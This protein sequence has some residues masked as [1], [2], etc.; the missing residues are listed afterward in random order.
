VS[1]DAA[2]EIVVWFD[3]RNGGDNDLFAL[4]LTAYGTRASG[5][6]VNGNPVCTSPGSQDTPACCAD[7]A[8]GA[9]ICWRDGRNAATS[10]D[11]YVQHLTGS[12]GI[13]PGLSAD[14]IPVSTALG[15][16]EGASICVD[17]RGGALIAWNDGRP[18]TPGVYMQHILPSGLVDPDWPANGKLIEANAGIPK[19]VPDASAGAI[20]LYAR[21]GGG[22]VAQ[23]VTSTGEAAPG[24]TPDGVMLIPQGSG[25]VSAC[26][27]GAGGA[28]VTFESGYAPFLAQRV[29][30]GGA[31]A[32][33]WPPAGVALVSNYSPGEFSP[34]ITPDDD[35]GAFVVWNAAPND[36]S[37]IFAQHVVGAGEVDPMWPTDGTRICA[38]SGE[39]R[40]PMAAGDESHGAY[41]VWY[42]PRIGSGNIYL[43]RV[44]P[45]GQLAPG[46]PIDGEPVELSSENTSGPLIVGSSLGAIATWVDSRG[47]IY[48]QR[49]D[50]SGVL[51]STASVA[52]SAPNGLVAFEPGPNPSRGTIRLRFDLPTASPAVVDIFDATGRLVA[53]PLRSRWMAAGSHSIEWD[54]QRAM[55][56]RAH[57]GVFF[58]RVRAARQSAISKVVLLQ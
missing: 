20:V 43:Q 7:G 45:T 49:V 57:P 9:F 16:Q 46:W 35:G 4:R 24:W 30:Q 8:G 13:A 3:T 37:D 17:G 15:T 39:Q 26:A 58:A 52:E 11:L 19:V 55:G 51:G 36:A 2:G 22:V 25:I 54:A 29:T 41:I 23:R 50:S 40:T 21:A 6:F 27:D 28:I 56:S 31:I 47:G 34:S 14:G 38:A 18:D 1:D 44:W 12:G 10:S 48:A 33:G 42:D 5:W 53:T 32:T